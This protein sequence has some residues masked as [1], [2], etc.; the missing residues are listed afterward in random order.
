MIATKDY[1]TTLLS[2]DLRSDNRKLEEYR[3]P[4][5]IETNISPKSEGSAKVTI[6]D[7]IVIAGIK[8]DIGEPFPDTQE[9]GNLMV[10]AELL[11]L[12]SP[13]F[14]SGPPDVHSIELAR[15]IDR[16]IR[17]SKC[18]DMK[19]LCI[20]KGEKVWNVFIDLYPINDSGNLFDAAGL[21]AL[22]AL[23]DAKFPECDEKEGKVIFGTK[24]KK[25]LPL[26][27]LPISCTLFKIG[28]KIIVDPSLEEEK[29]MDARLTIAT[30]E[31]NELCALQK[32][33]NSPL[34][35]EEIK[36]MIEI[37]IEKGKELRKLL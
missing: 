5:T 20:K 15:V 3:K 7:T 16:G 12:S 36:K 28:D 2:K 29:S 25:N 10:N 31:N 37:A 13:D 32:G 4:I 34:T 35:T 14:E 1:V 9:Q 21:A 22:A 11:P 26:T 24:T 18:I 8:M 19:K 17:E 23:K 33:G 27:K 6:G 30:L